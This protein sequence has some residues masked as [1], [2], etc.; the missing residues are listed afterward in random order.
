MRGMHDDTNLRRVKRPTTHPESDNRN[1]IDLGL[2]VFP[3]NLR[4]EWSFVSFMTN[5]QNMSVLECVR[6]KKQSTTFQVDTSL[7]LALPEPTELSIFVVVHAL[8]P[9]IK[10]IIDQAP[11][12]VLR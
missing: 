9:R 1:V 4:R 8:P 11:Q 10:S 6:C 3:Q 5:A 2:E 7:P 12:N